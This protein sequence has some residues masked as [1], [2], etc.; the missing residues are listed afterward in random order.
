MASLVAQFDKLNNQYNLIADGQKILIAVSGGLD[1]L[2][3]C[4][5]L[6]E[7]RCAEFKNLELSAAYVRQ[8]SVA[9]TPEELEE[10]VDLMSDWQI[11]FSILDSD[12]PASSQINCYICARAR[13]KQLFQ[14]AIMN[15]C[16][17]IAFGHNLDD[18]LGT[19]LMN[20]IFKG[21]LESLQPI[22]IQLGGRIR[23]IRPVLN[24]PKKHISA[25]GRAYGIKPIAPVCPMAICNKRQ[26]IKAMIA[27]FNRLNRSFRSNL[28]R[29]INHWNQLSI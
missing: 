25:I 26:D 2:V 1:S 9:L 18:Y 19:G 28:R 7:L 13:R 10:I 21:S 15:N 23:I 29:A 12:L 20:L 11:P 22:Q 16:N 17:A 8:K 6:C 4:C 24:W 3:L 5:L 14:F 27:R